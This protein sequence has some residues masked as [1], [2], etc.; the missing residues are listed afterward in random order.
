MRRRSNALKALLS[1]VAAV[2]WREEDDILAVIVA[3]FGCCV[4]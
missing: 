1:R 4:W 3:G 2:E